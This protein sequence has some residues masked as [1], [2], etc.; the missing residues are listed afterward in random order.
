MNEIIKSNS[1]GLDYNDGYIRRYCVIFNRLVYAP[2][3]E[4]VPMIFGYG[5]VKRIL[6]FS[7]F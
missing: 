4:C 7:H 6:S 2:G 3:D 1:N 5:D